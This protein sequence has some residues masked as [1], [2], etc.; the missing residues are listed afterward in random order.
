[1]PMSV[2]G[3]PV[4]DSSTGGSEPFIAGAMSSYVRSYTAISVWPQL[5][6]VSVPLVTVVP[7]RRH[8]RWTVSLFKRRCWSQAMIIRFQRETG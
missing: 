2:A 3:I 7:Q 4:G 5:G 8:S 1:M 6:Q